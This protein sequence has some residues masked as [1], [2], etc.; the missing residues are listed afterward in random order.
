MSIFPD[1]LLFNVWR[2]VARRDLIAERC[3]D[4]RDVAEW[5]DLEKYFDVLAIDDDTLI[6]RW[7]ADPDSDLVR[8]IRLSYTANSAHDSRV[9][10]AVSFAH[11]LYTELALP[12]DL[13]HLV[14]VVHRD[15]PFAMGHVSP[16]DPQLSF[17]D[18]RSCDLV[19]FDRIDGGG[20]GKA[21]FTTL[22]NAD[23][24]HPEVKK[25][26]KKKGEA[27]RKRKNQARAAS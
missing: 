4:E 3:L 2:R 15:H 5:F 1:T 19:R 18:G 20:P 6:A 10:K 14:V 27:R 22:I 11:A 9:N 8:D 12:L 26:L 23:L 25:T 17:T 21:R 24:M 7:S 13:D 16:E